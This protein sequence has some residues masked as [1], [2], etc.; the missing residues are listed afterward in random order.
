LLYRPTDFRS[1][2]VKLYLQTETGPESEP[3]SNIEK[4]QPVEQLVENT[5]LPAKYRYS[6]L[7]KIPVTDTSIAD[8]SVFIQEATFENSCYSKINRLLEKGVFELVNIKDI[9]QD[10]CIFNL[11]F[12]D[13]IK[14]LG[15]DKVFEKSRLVVQA[16][17]NQ[18]KSLILIQSPTI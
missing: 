7:R 14:Y 12:V 5:L 8:I 16:Y 3:E 2:T 11:Y 4:E 6:R 1:T 10:I 9:L 15:T 17:N 18:G 13:K